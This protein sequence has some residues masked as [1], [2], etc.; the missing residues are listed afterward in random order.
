VEG[1]LDHGPRR[2]AAA[3]GPLNPLRRGARPAGC[4]AFP[5][6]SC[7]TSG[8]AASRRDRSPRSRA[9]GTLTVGAWH[10]PDRVATRAGHNAATS[11]STC[12]RRSAGAPMTSA[13]PWSSTF[14]R[15]A[16][17]L[18]APGTH[19][20]PDNSEHANQKP[21]CGIDH[22]REHTEARRTTNRDRSSR[23]K[24]T[25]SEPCR[26]LRTTLTTERA[27]H[28]AKVPV[29]SRDTV[30]GWVAE[31]VSAPLRSPASRAVRSRRAL[32]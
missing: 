19:E 24:G 26:M 16:E 21:H 30:L 25:T 27:R 2:P 8:P 9:D 20:G 11:W 23:A 7:A 18:S 6:W 1:A 15:R 28:C 10:L 17:V 4:G 12:A 14:L 29:Y 32:G 3:D 22:E 31:A 5:S 13:N